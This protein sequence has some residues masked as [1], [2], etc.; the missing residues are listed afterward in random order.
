MRLYS[1]SVL[2]P[3][4][5]RPQSPQLPL[6]TRVCGSRYVSLGVFLQNALVCRAFR[7][8]PKEINWRVWNRPL[9]YLL[10]ADAF[11]KC[12]INYGRE[13]LALRGISS[14]AILQA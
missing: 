14:R 3:P 7:A 12:C 9:F 11:V 10:Q 6:E 1:D 4:S 8:Y 13:A 2:T 5:T